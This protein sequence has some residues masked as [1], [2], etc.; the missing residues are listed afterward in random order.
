MDEHKEIPRILAELINDM[1]ILAQEKLENMPSPSTKEEELLGKSIEVLKNYLQETTRLIKSK[2]ETAKDFLILKLKLESQISV[3]DTIASCHFNSLSSAFAQWWQNVF[4][5]IKS[6]I[7]L[8]ASS[9]WQHLLRLCTLKQWSISGGIS[10]LG[11]GQATLQ[12]NFD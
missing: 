8:I 2:Q 3:L 7:S 4:P 12:L 6:T 9:L 10:M 1:I 11:L 5:T